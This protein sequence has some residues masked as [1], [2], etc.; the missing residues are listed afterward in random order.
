MP[1]QLF[2]NVLFRG[3]FLFIKLQTAYSMKNDDSYNFLTAYV[4]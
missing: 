1:Y 4:Q 3:L 2:F